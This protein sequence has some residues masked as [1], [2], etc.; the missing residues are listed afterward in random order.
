MAILALKRSRTRRDPPYRRRVPTLR[1][2]GFSLLET[3]VALALFAAVLL[4]MLGTGQLILARLYDSDLRLRA[5]LDAQ[6]VIDSLRGTACARLASG[7]GMNGSLAAAWVVTDGLD[8]AQ[9]DVT[10]NV[11]QRRGAVARTQ[12]TTTLTPCPEL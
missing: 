7:T 6:S 8:L 12:R 3:I 2:A 4:S 11:P 1:R 5:S 9:L 10:V